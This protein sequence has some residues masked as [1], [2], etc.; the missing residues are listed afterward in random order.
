MAW[1]RREQDDENPF[2]R[3]RRF[4]DEQ[5]KAFFSGVPFVKRSFDDHFE[6][7]AAHHRKEIDA[8]LNEM[9]ENHQRWARD[10]ER[11]CLQREE[12]AE[13]TERPEYSHEPPLARTNCPASHE[14]E[15]ELEVYEELFAM[16]EELDPFTKRKETYPWLLSS[17]YSPLWLGMEAKPQPDMLILDSSYVGMLRRNSGLED[18][19]SKLSWQ[20]AFEDLLALERTGAMPDRSGGSP[21]AEH[22][23]GWVQKLV[24]GGLFPLPARQ[25][26]PDER[27]A[28]ALLWGKYLP[29]SDL[30][31]L[32]LCQE[33][34]RGVGEEKYAYADEH[35]DEED[36]EEEE[37]MNYDHDEIE[38][39]TDET[40]SSELHQK[41]LA[42][43]LAQAF[44]AVE[45]V[46]E[47]VVGIWPTTP[48]PHVAVHSTEPEPESKPSI[49][50][51]MTRTETRTL[52]DGAVETKR[53]L[54]RRF[55]DGNEE[56]EES[57]ET[58]PAARYAPPRPNAPDTTAN[59]LAS[60]KQTQTQTQE[61]VEPSQESTM[62][63]RHE[64]RSQGGVWF[65]R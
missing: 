21:V 29:I 43:T 17:K 47:D 46:V 48:E 27:S 22:P 16:A 28:V 41:A 49:V 57:I 62:S 33:V 40:S 24:A 25:N 35:Y 50:S 9:T 61:P 36:D 51:S 31:H 45:K 32:R 30:A 59:L 2:I 4:A 13:G 5:F 54:K 10:M 65:W 63:G 56:H 14:P 58:R 19:L 18:R 26:L 64:E 1:P 38:T 7:L 39:D 34:R 42:S 37:D 44:H 60:D 55:A 3:F 12:A 23:D 8:A 11:L 52:P 20:P 53:V 6:S 15:S